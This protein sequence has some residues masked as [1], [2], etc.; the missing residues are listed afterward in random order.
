[1]AEWIIHIGRFY[2]RFA[3]T[4]LKRFSAAPR[5]GYLRRLVKIF[6]Y[7]QN[8]TGSQES[9]VIL[10]K[11]Y[12]GDQWKGF[13]TLYWLDN[14]PD[15]SENINE[16]LPEPRGRPLSTTVYFYS[17]HSHDQVKRRSVSGG[18]FFVEST[19]II[20]SRKIQGYIK[21]SSYSE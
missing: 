10:P 11:V 6:G 5:E 1:M 8:A 3:V 15:L 2:V 21:I 9:I 17:N 13:N 12:K 18:M 4:S 14:Y 16:R 19:P 20:W 7:L